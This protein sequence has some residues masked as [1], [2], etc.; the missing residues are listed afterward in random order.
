MG[1]DYAPLEIVFGAVR[2]AK[3]Y[4]CEIVLVGDEAKIREVLS[5]E[6]GWEKLGISI[7]HASQ[8]IE[9]GEHPAD[10]VR[11]KKD[12]SI[13]VATRLVKDGVCDAVLSAGSTGAAVT[14]AQLILRRIK[15]IGRPTIA[16]PMRRR[17]A[18]HCSW[19]LGPMWTRSRSTSSR[20]ASWARSMR[21]TSSRSRTRVSV[22]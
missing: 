5:K 9:M 7:H 12:A 6:P 1:G 10:A 16:T 11:T 19:T 2:A 8:V 21:N 13:V 20:A 4:H 3:K 18:S 22:S 14:A 17:R 15:G